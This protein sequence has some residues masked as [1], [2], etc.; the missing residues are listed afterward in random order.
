MQLHARSSERNAYSHLSWFLWNNA[1]YLR[2]C[3]GN[4][5]GKVKKDVIICWGGFCSMG[6]VNQNDTRLQAPLKQVQETDG[7]SL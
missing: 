7:P 2:N 5:V 6:G 1:Q 3:S 4:M